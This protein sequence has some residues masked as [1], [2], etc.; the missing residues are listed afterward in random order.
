MIVVADASPINYLILIEK[1]EVLPV[2]FGRIVLPRAV[3]TELLD[4]F[5]PERVRAWALNIPAWVDVRASTRTSEP[6]L[7]W[8]GRGEREA[9]LIAEDIAA[10][11][12][13]V[14]EKQGRDEARRRGIQTIGT[15]AV[16]NAAADIGLL[17][18][19]DTLARLQKTNFFLTAELIAQLLNKKS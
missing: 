14:D 8:L 5:A 10:D 15:L 18:L 4:P 9:I 11:R 1:V 19:A 2:L 16:L 12:F 6:I 3:Q 13:L 17:D 7:E